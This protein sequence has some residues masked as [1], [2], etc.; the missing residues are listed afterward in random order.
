[1]VKRIA[2]VIAIAGVVVFAAITA[3]IASKESHIR[4]PAIATLVTLSMVVAAYLG[5]VAGG[6]AFRD[7]PASTKSRAIAIVFGIAAMLGALWLFWMPSPQAQIG[8]AMALLAAILSMSRYFL[9]AGLMPRWLAEVHGVAIPLL[10][11]ILA[12]ALLLL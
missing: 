11:V 10:G 2:W 8:T 9:A 12:V 4:I 3:F 6:L 5:G 1:M 7:E